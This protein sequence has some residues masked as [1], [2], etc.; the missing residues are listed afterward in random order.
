[1][2]GSRSRKRSK[3]NPSEAGSKTSIPSEVQP[4]SS[5]S[6]S[7]ISQNTL[8][9]A[10]TSMPSSAAD[11]TNGHE[12]T[13]ISQPIA[14]GEGDGT[15][16]PRSLI[17]K[18][19]HKTRSWYGSWPRGPPKSSPSTQVARETIQGG[20]L[21]SKGTID[22]SRYDTKK[23]LDT[24]SV[25]VVNEL[26]PAPVTA[27]QQAAN[28]PIPATTEPPKPAEDIPAKDTAKDEHAEDV[29]MDDG[30]MTRTNEL[31][32]IQDNRAAVVME[33]R[34]A[35]SSSW[36]GW[37]ARPPVPNS[38][39]QENSQAE[40]E[41]QQLQNAEPI[42][43]AAAATGSATVAASEEPSPSEPAK[44]AIPEEQVSAE[45]QT[46]AGPTDQQ[47]S[48]AV[49]VA[50]RS[51]W[52]GLWSGAD[53][54]VQS[55]APAPA[56][57]TP[58]VPEAPSEPEP[59]K[60][61]EDV[62]ME[63]APPH[64]T[65]PTPPPKAGS[66][67]AFWSRDTGKSSDK[68]PAQSP[69]QGQ[70]AV[71]GE[72]SE[73]HPQRAN[74]ID[75]KDTPVK[76]QP[77]SSAK[78]S[79]QPVKGTPTVA[80]ESSSK[81]GKRVR[82]Q[83]LDLDEVDS[84]PAT[85]KSTTSKPEVLVKAESSTKSSNGK[86]QPQAVV[87]PP[88]KNLL[89]PVFNNTY[90]V[91]ENPTLIQ[92]IA[93][94]LLRTQQ[95]P[96]RHVHLSKEPFKFKRALSIGVHG[97]FPANYLRPMI[98]QP[99]GTSIKFANHGAEAIRRWADANGNKDC[100]IEKVALEGEGRI[101]ERVE[102]LWKL[103]LNWIDHIRKADV[104]LFACHSQG[105]PVSIILLAKLLELGIITTAKVGICAMAG[106][107]L[108]PF[109]DYRSGMGMLMGSAAQLWEFA[110]PK[111]EVSRRLE[112]ALK[113]ALSYG[114]RVTF[115]GSI[116][117]QLVPLESAIY[118]PAHHPHIYRAVFIDG[119]VHAPDFIA[120]LVGFALKLRN[121]G[122]TDH[123][124]IRELSVPLAGSLYSGEG[125]SRLYDDE[126]VYDLAVRHTLET[127]S[128][129]NVPCEVHHNYQQGGGPTTPNNPYM[130]PW[131]M[132]GLLE[133]DFVKSELHSETAELLRQFD[134]WKPT[135]KALKDVKYRLEAVRSKL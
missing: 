43:E 97:L 52:F 13:S 119:R 40:P 63:D 18:Q 92:Q 11:A 88:A 90:H 106:V 85:P 37:F 78:S 42:A 65:L 51:S 27:G 81:K 99:T 82:P 70:L 76:E 62:V 118:A 104:I 114:A 38:K 108:G 56:I 59:M 17:T 20:T 84:R 24:M 113:A 5:T 94:L 116:D 29:P 134:D 107:S 128:V 126:Q 4:E 68:K 71:I 45:P 3:P 31:P 22:L 44:T 112:A 131:I 50:P 55:Y 79:E 125:H 105:V 91:K 48:S 100:E 32:S 96:A 86:P 102:N 83:S 80:K 74:A 130:L 28:E 124:L 117:D 132:R 54:S 1:M 36:L 111:S 58:V 103:L 87:K 30:E 9:G 66:T 33:Q 53:T 19:P 35:A 23:S 39:I 7:H 95:P 60:E 115:V 72:G 127:T 93:Q 75:V 2:M 69:E 15:S 46:A 121:L 129:G 89:L 110:D 8:V 34:P 64:D 77:L 26:E 67:W 98:G 57:T 41:Q 109:P 101:G 16:T 49:T 12:R 6:S 25:D 120:H 122:V 61:P 73:S 14:G 21:K 47:Q 133:E 10:S 135:T 123:G